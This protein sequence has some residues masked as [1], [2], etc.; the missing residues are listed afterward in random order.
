[1][2]T[3][4]QAQHT[5]YAESEWPEEWVDEEMRMEREVEVGEWEERFIRKVHGVYIQPGSSCMQERTDT[6]LRRLEE[7]ELVQRDSTKRM[8]G[9]LPMWRIF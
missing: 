4:Q 1:M 9:L 7:L 8:E 5:T 2:H 3:T 6:L